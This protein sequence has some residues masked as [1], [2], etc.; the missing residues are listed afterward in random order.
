MRTSWLG[1]PRSTDS[2]RGRPPRSLKCSLAYGAGGTRTPALPAASRTLWPTELQPREPP[3]LASRTRIRADKGLEALREYARIPVRFQPLKSE[4]LLRL[5]IYDL[6]GEEPTRES[7]ATLREDIADLDA[8]LDDTERSAEAP[9]HRRKY[10]LL[11]TGFLRRLL[12][13]HLE[14]VTQVERDLG[15]EGTCKPQRRARSATL[16]GSHLDR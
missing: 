6:L 15:P 2:S 3:S 12:D 10:L 7:V 13:L 16:T 11:A 5:L 9:P 1:R 4:L 14:P 8:R